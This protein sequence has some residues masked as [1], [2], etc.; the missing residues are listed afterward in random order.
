[1][2]A[3]I[4]ISPK[5][6]ISVSKWLDVHLRANF[7]RSILVDRCSN[8][9][10]KR[11]HNSAVMNML[12]ERSGQWWGIDEA[13]RSNDEVSWFCVKSHPITHTL[14]PPSYKIATLPQ[15]LP[16]ALSLSL[17]EYVV[18]SVV[19]RSVTQYCVRH[20][21]AFTSKELSCSSSSSLQS[22][23]TTAHDAIFNI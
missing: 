22:R 21:D 9:I 10:M 14:Y 16:L 6:Q 20:L 7:R 5:P 23:E 4:S 17:T 18:R 3:K 15:R 8:V 19:V 2:A 1:M 11:D 12:W 13:S